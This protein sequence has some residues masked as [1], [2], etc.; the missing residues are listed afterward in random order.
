MIF[1]ERFKTKMQIYIDFNNILY[2]LQGNPPQLYARLFM[3]GGWLILLLSLIWGFYFAYIYYKKRSHI[4][5]IEYTLFAIDVPKENEK[6]I[7]AV[8]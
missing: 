8:E 1:T 4:K 5:T 2:N 7:Q 3:K 6:S